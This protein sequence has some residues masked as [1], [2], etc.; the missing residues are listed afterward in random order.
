MEN[1]ECG[2]IKLACDIICVECEKIILLM[3]LD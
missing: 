3:L 1:I 2:N